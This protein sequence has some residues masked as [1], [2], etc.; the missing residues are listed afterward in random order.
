VTGCAAHCCLAHVQYCTVLYYSVQGSKR[1]DERAVHHC[2]CA[3]DSCFS[4]VQHSDGSVLA[5][6]RM[7]VGSSQGYEE[8]LEEIN[9]LGSLKHRHPGV[10]PRSLRGPAASHRA[11]AYL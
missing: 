4:R 7:Q 2:P 3:L 9:L 1:L 5:V 8:F 6:K 10:P 11:P